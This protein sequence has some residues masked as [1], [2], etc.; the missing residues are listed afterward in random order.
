M[1]LLHGDNEPASRKELNR[2][3]DSARLQG[4]RVERIDGLTT[5]KALLEIVIGS[6]SLFGDDRVVVVENILSGPQS[7]RKQELMEYLSSSTAELILWEKKTVTATTLKKLPGVKPQEFKIS[8][9]LFVWLDNLSPQP[10]TKKQQLSLLHQ[11]LAN[12]APEL[13]LTML[14]R[15]L[16][17]LIQSKA[18]PP[19]KAAPFVVAKLQRQAKSFTL[20]QLLI[21]HRRLYEI[22]FKQKTS[23]SLLTLEAE[24]DLLILAL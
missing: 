5:T 8:N 12:D 15:Q 17:L 24:L 13:C 16:R 1:I 20:D 21:T 3:L 18:G 6:D 4:K 19:P 23:T 2:L 22:D 14:A 7:K 11:I 9:Q 10:N